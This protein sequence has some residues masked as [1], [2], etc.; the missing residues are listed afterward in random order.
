MLTHA[1]LAGAL[2]AMAVPAVAH[3]LHAPAPVPVSATA[4]ATA[5]ATAD[6]TSY[7]ARTP[8]NPLAGRPWGNADGAFDPTVEAWSAASG[9]ERVLLEKVARQPKAAW[10]GSWRSTSR[11][12]DVVRDYVAQ[13]QDGNPETLVQMALFRMEPWGREACS[14]LSTPQEQADYKAWMDAVALGIGDAH[15]A[16]IQQPD[17]PKTLCAPK[18]SK[19][20]SKLIA[21]GTKKLSALPH[22]SVYVEI[23]AADWPSD[24][25]A[26]SA[27]IAMRGGVRWARGFALN[28]THYDST[29][30]Q[31]LYAERVS[32]E[33]AARGL[34]GKTAVV[35][36]AQN[37]RPFQGND[38]FKTHGQVDT[39]ATPPAAGGTCFDHIPVCTK[40]KQRKVCVALGI[41]P[42]TEVANPAWGL[43]AKADRA[44]L[45]YV[46][47][48]LWFGRPWLFMQN[49]PF[50]V[51]R[52]LDLART[53]AY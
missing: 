33:L 3:A 37:G 23:G 2:L 7:A 31:V 49:Q 35:S 34:P 29:E 53:W 40:P 24:D 47:A 32:R 18:G 44:A 5:T 36:T 16:V 4:T 48:Y 26:L 1:G 17:G 10:F 42:T 27:K 51:D 39:C 12:T 43:S 19:A 9:E 46:D 20:H 25:P 41:P 21:Y 15:V 45:A 8:G 52:T 11:V 28:S 30:R 38:F 14:R 13:V 50:L 6:E 22:T